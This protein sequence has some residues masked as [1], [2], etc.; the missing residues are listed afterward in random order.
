MTYCGSLT[1]FDNS[2]IT[3]ALGLDLKGESLQ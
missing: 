2:L 1:A 3:T